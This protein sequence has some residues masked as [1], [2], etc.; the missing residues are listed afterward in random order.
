MLEG[1]TSLKC[2]LL[3]GSAFVDSLPDAISAA[4]HGGIAAAVRLLA[5]GESWIMPSADRPHSTPHATRSNCLQGV[6]LADDY[7]ADCRM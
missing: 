1:S 2:G 6:D 7:L 4:E 3:Q 5:G